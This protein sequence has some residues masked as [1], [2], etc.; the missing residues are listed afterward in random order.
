MMIYDKRIVGE[1]L[2]GMTNDAVDGQNPALVGNY[3]IMGK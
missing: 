1:R 2:Y 3:S